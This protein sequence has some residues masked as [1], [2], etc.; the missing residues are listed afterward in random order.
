MKIQFIFSVLCFVLISCRDSNLHRLTIL[1][2]NKQTIDS[3]KIR[4]AGLA[5]KFGAIKTGE[6]ETQGFVVLS[7]SRSEGA[8]FGTFFLHN[9]DTIRSNF[10]YFSNTDDIQDKIV[11]IVDSSGKI[12]EKY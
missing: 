6:S 11:V 4:V 9:A 3:A 10:G 5:L 7:E 12:K 2:Q 1:N 8:F